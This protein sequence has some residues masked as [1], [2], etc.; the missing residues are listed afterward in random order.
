MVRLSHRLLR[1]LHCPTV[2]CSGGGIAGLT[3]AVA[4]SKHRDI[5]I[6]IYEGATQFSD[7]IGGGLG[8]WLRTRKVM[9]Q[10]GLDADLILAS[11]TMSPVKEEEDGKWVNWGFCLVLSLPFAIIISYRIHLSKERPSQRL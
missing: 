3:C 2:A 8:M 9:R 1:S 11:D 6:D 5:S 4:L 10:L 7:L